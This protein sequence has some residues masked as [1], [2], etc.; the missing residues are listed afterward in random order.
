MAKGE[1]GIRKRLSRER[2]PEG[3]MS[4]GDH[5]RELR[6]RV[7]VAAIAIFVGAGVGWWQY[8]Y[9]FARISEPI[10]ELALRRGFQVATL[11][12]PDLTGSFTMRITVSLFVGVV[13]A[14]PIWLFQIWGFIVPGLTGREKRTAFYFIG[15]AVPLFL[16]GCF[17][18]V[19]TLPRAAAALLSFTPDSA[20]NILPANEYFDF[21][22]R[23]ILAFGIAF[24]LPVFLVGLNAAHI[25]PARI[26]LKA[27]RPAVFILFV[28]AAV[29]TPTP[30]AWTMLALAV[31]MIGLFFAAVGVCFLL[32]RRR[33]KRDPTSEWADLADDEASP[34]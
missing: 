24:L 26:L 7:L 17:L 29:M 18:G 6:R 12:Y 3:R 5:L 11:N 22:M 15:S 2:D 33:A 4:L 34:L 23:F 27:W 30:D 14:S 1:A 21:V 28:F 20:S 8:D 31:P 9:L 25:L 13:I 19:V 16:T 10:T 32:D